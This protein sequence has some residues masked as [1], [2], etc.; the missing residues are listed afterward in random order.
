MSEVTGSRAYERSNPAAPI[1][2]G[3]AVAAIVCFIIADWV[4]DVLWP[5]SGALGLAAVAAAIV[6]LRRARDGAPYRR[7]ALLALVLGAL[8]IVGI[9]IWAILAGTGVV[10]D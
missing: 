10:E 4:S 6:G 5:L 9:V 1:A 7:L 3:F 8:P 2:I